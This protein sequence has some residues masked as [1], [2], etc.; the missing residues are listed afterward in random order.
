[1]N[2]PRP[3]LFVAPVFARVFTAV[4][5]V[6]VAGNGAAICLQGTIAG[7]DVAGTLISAVIFSYWLHLLLISH[8]D[9][10]KCE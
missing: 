4:L 6:A 7:R 3:P 5:A 1:M 10:A 8:D 2:D 9:A